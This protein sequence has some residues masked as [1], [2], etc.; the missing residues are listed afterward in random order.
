MAGGYAPRLP[1]RVD[2]VYGPYGLITDQVELVR[3]NFKMLLLTI[4][5]ERIMNPDFGVGLKR[6]LFERSGPELH[7]RINEKISEQ[8]NRYMDYIQLNKID[9]TTPAPG[10]DFYPHTL[11]ITIH[12]T[13]IPLATST[14][15][16]IDFGN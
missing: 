16:E 8:V 4:P 3:Q 2:E 7:N 6:Y 11:S 10:P 1:L 15:I 9:F 12:F 13:I 5:G 14:T